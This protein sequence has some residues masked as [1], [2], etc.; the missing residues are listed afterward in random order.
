MN[1]KE[2]HRPAAVFSQL[3]D[4]FGFVYSMLVSTLLLNSPV[5]GSAMFLCG[6]L[7]V[8]LMGGLGEP[9][10]RRLRKGTRI[11]CYVLGCLMLLINL[12]LITYYPPQPD[13][14]LNWLVFSLIAT[15]VLTES[16]GHRLVIRS[17][18]MHWEPRRFFLLYYSVFAFF[19]VIGTVLLLALHPDRNVWQM[20]IGF[21][22][23]LVYIAYTHMKAYAERSALNAP[24]PEQVDAIRKILSQNRVFIAFEAMRGLIIAAMQL[25][26]ITVFTYLAVTAEQLLISMLIALSVSVAVKELSDLF[27]RRISER[28]LSDP[29][30]ITALGLFLWF[31]G[32]QTADR[33]ME[34]SAGDAAG[35]YI[36]LG[37]CTVGISLCVSRLEQM[38]HVVR[39]AGAFASHRSMAGYSRIRESETSLFVFLGQLLSLTAFTVYLVY[40][41]LRSRQQVF[42][43]V[44]AIRPT[45]ALPALVLVAAAF[46]ASIRYPFTLRYSEK[47]DRAMKLRSKGQEN[48]ALEKQILPVVEGKRKRPIGTHVLIVL[49]RPFLRHKLQNAEQIRPDPDN[50]LIFL[51]NHGEIYGPLVAILFLPVHVRPWV[52]SEIMIT[53]EEMADY[54]YRYT[55]SPWKWMPEAWKMPFCRHILATLS[56]WGMNQLEAIPVYRNKPTMLMK[57][58]RLSAEALQS[59]DNL[60]IYPENPD[61]EGMLPGY[62]KEGVGPLFSGFA[63]IAQV[64]WNKTG[65]RCRFMPMYCHKKRRTMTFGT[66]IL[67]DPEA[68]PNEERER[69]SREAWEQMN[70]ICQAEEKAWQAAQKR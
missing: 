7:A 49:L 13:M 2:T 19:F 27:A 47:L 32:L 38:E 21:L 14:P 66:E 30:N 40:T 20:I 39:N 8:F 69:I 64:Y 57:T 31:Y 59:G 50:P 15:I 16:F 4:L 60:L 54:V 53:K 68:D 5:T 52:I 70:A 43:D 29:V 24:P 9:E 23:I 61:A 62:E 42:P 26:L 35:I 63:L 3:I 55:V 37:I 22:M 51:C 33:L 67:Y 56:L 25:T 48:P 58:M 17:S 6:R 41:G 28:R 12:L 1:L 11:F 34:S 46:L 18:G 44:S 65:K 45:L 36:A 10:R